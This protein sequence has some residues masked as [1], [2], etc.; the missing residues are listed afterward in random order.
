MELT[1]RQI[2]NLKCNNEYGRVWSWW[3]YDPKL[4]ISIPYTTG[5]HGKGM[6]INTGLRN[7]RVKGKD[8]DLDGMKDYRVYQRLLEYF[9][10]KASGAPFKREWLVEDEWP[11]D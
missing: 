1:T 11:N 10:F 4:D 2:D 8:F 3:V 9:N 5:L 7:V 6:F